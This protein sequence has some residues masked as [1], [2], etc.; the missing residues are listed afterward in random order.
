V[1]WY[2][3]NAYQPVLPL[4]R[5]VLGYAIAATVAGILLGATQVAAVVTA[6]PSGAAY[7]HAWQRGDSADF[8]ASW[9]VVQY[10]YLPLA[11]VAY[12]AGSL[13]LWHARSNVATMNPDARQA[14]SRGWAW[15]AWV[16]PVVGFWFPYQVVRDTVRATVREMT[17]GVSIGVWWALWLG[18][19]LTEPWVSWVIFDRAPSSTHLLGVA[20]TLDAVACIGALV[21]WLRMIWQVCVAQES[22]LDLRDQQLAAAYR[23][24]QQS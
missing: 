13:W 12:L 6:W 20:E 4:P 17:S 24:A 21:L 14:R 15:G 22:W 7:G 16:T 8:N 1:Y 3:L 11:L 2:P 23:R 18:W 5:R 9:D 10:L 19:L